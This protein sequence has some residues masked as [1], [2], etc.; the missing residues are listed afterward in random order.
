MGQAVSRE[1]I[2]VS[3]ERLALLRERAEGQYDFDYVESEGGDRIRFDLGAV[4]AWA[5]I[6]GPDPINYEGDKRIIAKLKKVKL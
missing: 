3:R 5:D 1:D 6:A 2:S 4:S